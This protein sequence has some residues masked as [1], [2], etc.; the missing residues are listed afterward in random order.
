MSA[1]VVTKTI[2]AVGNTANSPKGRLFFY[3][4][5]LAALWLTPASSQS[6]QTIQTVVASVLIGVAT[7]DS[8]IHLWG[9]GKKVLGSLCVLVGV[10]FWVAT[11]GGRMVQ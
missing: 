7:A 10:G 6:G 5:L 9:S 4:Y 8:S 11:V 2:G 3:A 1:G